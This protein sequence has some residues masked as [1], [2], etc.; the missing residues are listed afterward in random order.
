MN[1]SRESTRK[2]RGCSDARKHANLKGHLYDKP[3]LNLKD[4]NTSACRNS[5]IAFCDSA[6]K[7]DDSAAMDN[8]R[9]STKFDVDNRGTDVVRWAESSWLQ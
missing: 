8:G 6:N 7:L 4:D 2:W 3:I 1:N 9:R 5:N